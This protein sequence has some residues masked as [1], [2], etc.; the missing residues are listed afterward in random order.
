MKLW[1]Y[2][3]RE[4]GVQGHT[5]EAGKPDRRRRSFKSPEVEMERN[6]EYDFP[7]RFST[8]TIN[9][10]FAIIHEKNIRRV[11]WQPAIGANLNEPGPSDVGLCDKGERGLSIAEGFF[12]T[13]FCP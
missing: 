10:T 8:N 13:F 6:H 1:G 12:V 2:E 11:R 5:D 3:G 7:A 4:N 9:N